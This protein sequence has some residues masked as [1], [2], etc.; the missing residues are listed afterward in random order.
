MDFEDGTYIFN[1]LLSIFLVLLSKDNDSLNY[2]KQCKHHS[3]A[4]DIKA[5]LDE[6]NENRGPELIE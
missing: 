1:N 4:P 3:S 5:Q 2:F 6:I